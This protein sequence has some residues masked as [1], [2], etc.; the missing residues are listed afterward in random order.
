MELVPAM[1]GV[2]NP[3]PGQADAIAGAR[4]GQMA[5]ITEH[6]LDQQTPALLGSVDGVG[7]GTTGIQ[8]YVHVAVLLMTDRL[9][10]S[11]HAAAGRQNTEPV[12]VVHTC[13]QVHRSP[14]GRRAMLPGPHPRFRFW[15]LGT[16][17]RR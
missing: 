10:R 7:Q 2:K 8:V 13:E 1:I 16:R 11:G 3:C 12:R 4:D 17:L 14:T 6:E 5:A 9:D 15:D